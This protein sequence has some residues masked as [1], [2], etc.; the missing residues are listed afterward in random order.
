GVPFSLRTSFFTQDFLFSQ[1]S[2][3]VP[4]KFIGKGGVSRESIAPF[5][6]SYFSILSCKALIKRLACSGV[7]TIR[8]FT[9]VFG[10]P[11]IMRRKSTTN[12]VFEWVII[13]KLEYIP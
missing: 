11:G 7:S 12:S 1:A 10:T 5:T 2:P 8:D 9:R 3:V 4:P 6:F 13:A